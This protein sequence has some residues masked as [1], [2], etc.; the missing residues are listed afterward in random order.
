MRGTWMAMALLIAGCGG[1]SF[2]IA[3]A[4]DAELVE[5]SVATNDSALVAD[6]TSIAET[7]A[8][9]SPDAEVEAGADAAAEAEA[10]ADASADVSV[11]ALSC[12]ATVL[13]FADRDGD[14]F[15]AA[16]GAALVACSCPTGTTSKSPTVTVDCNDED[17]R[18]HPGATMFYA[19]P[20]CV[21]GT[22]CSVKSWD[23]NCNGAVEEQY[24]VLTACP[25]GCTGAGYAAETECGVTATVTQCVKELLC[26][27]KTFGWTQ[28]C[29]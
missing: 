25:S 7:E 12:D 6:D 16:G 27:K 29:R 2:D 1:E 22:S 23:Y 21:P 17:P 3:P 24:G 18:V 8:E 19:A 5:T 4:A 10:S 9:A 13:C 26:N 20:Y 28:G 14:G 15:A 11:D